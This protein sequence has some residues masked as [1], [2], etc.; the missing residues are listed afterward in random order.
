M[1]LVTGATGKVGRHLVAGL[2]AAPSWRL[3]IQA[4]RKR[5]VYRWRSGSAVGTKFEDWATER[6]T[7]RTSGQA[8]LRTRFEAAIERAGEAAR[9]RLIINRAGLAGCRVIKS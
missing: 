4:G 8:E 3:S 2:P 1:I 9:T 6:E 5:S 7:A